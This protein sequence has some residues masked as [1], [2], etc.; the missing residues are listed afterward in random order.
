MR[1]TIASFIITDSM[2]LDKDK[3]IK[4]LADVDYQQVNYKC[5]ETYNK[6]YAVGF[7]VAGC[8]YL[9]GSEEAYEKV[10]NYDKLFSD[11]ITGLESVT[12]V[13]YIGN[14]DQNIHLYLEV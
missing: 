5:I 10:A 8:D 11:I 6:K 3:L 12:I 1:K 2:K 9:P 4:T 7:V 13:T 14:I